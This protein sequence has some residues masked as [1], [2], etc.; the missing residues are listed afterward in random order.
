MACYAA[1]TRTRWS[2]HGKSGPCAFIKKMMMEG[3]EDEV[4][5]PM[6]DRRLWV[7]D[8]E[9]TMRL[10]GCPH[11]ADAIRDIGSFGS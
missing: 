9:A 5:M 2:K 11:I 10:R 7:E 1:T 4:V 3:D 8:C 6:T